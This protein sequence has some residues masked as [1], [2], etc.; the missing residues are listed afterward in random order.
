MTKIFRCFGVLKADQLTSVVCTYAI[1]ECIFGIKHQLIN[2]LKESCELTLA[3]HFSLKSLA[4][5]ALF[6]K[7]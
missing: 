5:S 7:I 1:F 6:E 4:K 2:Y 3:Q